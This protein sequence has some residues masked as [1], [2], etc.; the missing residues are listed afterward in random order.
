VNS[1]VTFVGNDMI[2]DLNDRGVKI[3]GKMVSLPAVE[4]HVAAVCPMPNC[5][6]YQARR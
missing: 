1:R 4:G 2:A 3:G 5:R 6:H